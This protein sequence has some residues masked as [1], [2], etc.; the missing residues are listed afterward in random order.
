MYDDEK[1]DPNL[2]LS[3]EDILA[4]LIGSVQRIESMLASGEP[5]PW[6]ERFS[7]RI[8]RLEQLQKEHHGNGHSGKV[9]FDYQ[10]RK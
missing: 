10:D 9:L 7:K 2:K 1:T 5:P 4:N 8:D 3:L 6:F